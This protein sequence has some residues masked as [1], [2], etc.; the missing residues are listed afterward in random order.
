MCD[1]LLNK[2]VQGSKGNLH[3]SEDADKVDSADKVL[4]LLS[5]GALR[6]QP[7]KKL[8]E[9]LAKDR[10]LGEDRLILVCRTK[11]EGW[12]FD[13][14]ENGE[15]KDAPSEVRVAL[16]EHEAVKYRAPCD[17]GSRHEFPTMLQHL[18]GRLLRRK[19]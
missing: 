4:L 8:C 14:N 16:Q 12:S 6:G 15:V 17:G 3:V 7:L 19:A 1:E 11:E 2:L 13:P 9:A 10:A 5:E 18:L